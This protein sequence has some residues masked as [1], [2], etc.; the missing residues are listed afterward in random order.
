MS[1]I[2][3]DD[4]ILVWSKLKQIADDIIKC[5]QNKKNRVENIGRKGEIACFKQ[6]L[7]FSQCFPKLCLE[8]RQ[9]AALCG[10]GLKD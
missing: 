3:A 7:F 10:N 2:N 5:I 8:V 6:F 1:Q 9:N 4:K